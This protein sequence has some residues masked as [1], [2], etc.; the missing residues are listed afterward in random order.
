MVLVSAANCCFLVYSG[1]YEGFGKNWPVFY[2]ALLAHVLF[3]G[4]LLLGAMLVEGAKLTM[5]WTIVAAG[6]L[7]AAAAIVVVMCR[8]TL[9]LHSILQK[10]IR[11]T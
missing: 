7:V 8:R 10:S 3:E 11:P 9:S 6:S 2:A 5:L 1:V 4:P